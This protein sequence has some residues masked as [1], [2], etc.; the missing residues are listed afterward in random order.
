[1]TARNLGV[2]FGRMLSPSVAR[3]YFSGSR[4]D[5]RSNAYAFTQFRI[6]V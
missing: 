1:M 4:D 6:R 3:F 2:V 5:R